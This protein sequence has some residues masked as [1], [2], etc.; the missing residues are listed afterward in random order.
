ME[1]FICKIIYGRKDEEKV[2]FVLLFGLLLFGVFSFGLREAALENNN[3]GDENDMEIL[4]EDIMF[5]N[6]EDS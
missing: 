4:Q 5:L 6:G 3:Y 2:F 1:S